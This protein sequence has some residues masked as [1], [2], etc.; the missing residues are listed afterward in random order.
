MNDEIKLLRE[1]T[2]K[3]LSKCYK[4][5]NGNERVCFGCPFDKMGVNCFS[6]LI[7]YAYYLIQKDEEEQEK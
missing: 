2:L 6:V 4:F 7:S 5:C 3:G 1:K